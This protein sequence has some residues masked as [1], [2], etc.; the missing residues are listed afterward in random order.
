MEQISSGDAYL[1]AR[2]LQR[3]L[4]AQGVRPV[5]VVTTLSIA[6]GE[7][8]AVNCQRDSIADVIEKSGLLIRRVAALTQEDLSSATE[9]GKN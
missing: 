2:E 3:W 1:L 8:V 7:C 5:D 4:S 6:L 9:E